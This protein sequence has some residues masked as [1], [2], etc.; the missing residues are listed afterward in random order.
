MKSFLL[1]FFLCFVGI[2]GY[3]QNYEI[4]GIVVGTDGA[5]LPGVSI[6]VKKFN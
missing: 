5:P 6:V 2:F 4:K 3:S 1:S